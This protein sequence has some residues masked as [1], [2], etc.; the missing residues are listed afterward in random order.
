MVILIPSCDNYKDMWSLLDESYRRYWPD[1]PYRKYIITNS[2]VSVPNGFI[3]CNVWSDIDWSSNCKK[4][5]D[6]I[7]ADYILMHIDDLLFVKKVSQA[8]IDSCLTEFFNISWNYLKLFYTWSSIT[9]GIIGEIAFNEEYRTSTVF[10]VWKKSVLS[11]LL[12][13]WE[14]PWQF[15]VDGTERSRIYDRWFYTPLR[16]ITY[17]NLVIKRKLERYSLFK[18]MKLW[19]IYTGS[20]EKMSYWQN[21][22]YFFKNVIYKIILLL[23]LSLKKLLIKWARRLW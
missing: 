16:S 11:S 3:A 13:N 22:L 8:Y 6:M 23:P 4:A 20:R 17:V 7:D 19:F 10:S 12:I 9:N 15:E 5:L 1:C 14:S 21:F 2:N 18:I